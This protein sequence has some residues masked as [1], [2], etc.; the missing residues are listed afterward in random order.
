MRSPGLKS[1][2]SQSK[3]SFKAQRC[4]VKGRFGTS[5]K[6]NS[7]HIAYIMREGAGANGNVPVSLGN[8]EACKARVNDSQYRENN[9]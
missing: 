6:G 3:F 9:S 7:A 5:T 4:I 8:E 2:R 1:R